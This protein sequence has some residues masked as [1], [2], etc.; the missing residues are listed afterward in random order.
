MLSS[1]S[2]SHYLLSAIGTGLFEH[3]VTVP[4]VMEYE[5]VLLRP[6]M[7]PLSAAAVLD[8]VDYLRPHQG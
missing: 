1:S 7:V 8:V 5:D 2:W 3:V 4:L 6:G